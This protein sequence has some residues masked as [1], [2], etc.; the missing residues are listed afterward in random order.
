MNGFK[1]FIGFLTS[2][3]AATSLYAE[4]ATISGRITDPND[5][6]VQNAIVSVGD[7]FE[8]TDV[9]GKYRIKD[10]PLGKQKLQIKKDQ[11]VREFE[12]DVNQ[13]QITKDLTLK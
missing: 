10:I 11:I 6:A 7:K 2:L 4:T 5:K 12:L 9:D 13:A 1:F 8:F 3:L